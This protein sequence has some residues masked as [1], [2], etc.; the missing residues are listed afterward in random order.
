VHYRPYAPADFDQLYAIE[1]LCFAPNLRFTRRYMRELFRRSQT[2][3]WVA[4]KNNQLGG[5]AAAAWAVR[6][7]GIVAYIET[8]EVLPDFRGHGIGS[9]LLRRIEGSA[10]AAGAHTIWLHVDAR[11]AGAIRLYESLQ[12]LCEGGR[13]DFY[14]DGNA[15]LIY[16]KQLSNGVLG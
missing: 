2:A 10:T 12:Y 3:T 11:N 7:V 1:A 9:E 13:E 6:K 16:R 5:F 15:A 8:I 14:P 4:E